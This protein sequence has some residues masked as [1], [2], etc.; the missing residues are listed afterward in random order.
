MTFAYTKEMSKSR[1][2]FVL[3]KSLILQWLYIS[4]KSQRYHGLRLH[5]IPTHRFI[6]GSSLNETYFRFE[7]F[8]EVL[9]TLSKNT[10]LNMG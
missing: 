5:F 2:F 10:V 9:R 1:I 7:R 8:M 3:K 6:K 4:A